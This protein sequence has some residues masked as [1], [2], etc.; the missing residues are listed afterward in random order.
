VQA[1]ARRYGNG[2]G[3]LAETLRTVRESFGYLDQTV[4][5]F[6]ALLLDVPI[7]RVYSEADDAIQPQRKHTCVV[8]TGPACQLKGANALLAAVEEV[9]GLKPGDATSDGALSLRTGHCLGA[10]G[11]APAAVVDGIVLGNVEPEVMLAQVAKG[12]KSF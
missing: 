11:L 9:H 10:C 2:P 6:V 8:C 4:L 3:A 5:R 7:A 1:A 12:V